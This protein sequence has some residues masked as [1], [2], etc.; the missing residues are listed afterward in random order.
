M[1]ISILSLALTVTVLPSRAA[2]PAPKAKLTL[3]KVA[4]KESDIPTRS[5]YIWTPAV[6]SITASTLPVLYILHGW[7]GSPSSMI[8]ATV[9]TFQKSFDGGAQPFIAVFPDGNAVTHPDSEWADSS[10]KKAMIETWLIKSVIP[11]VEGGN[12]RSRANRGI[13]G[14]SMGGYG[15]TII[16]LHHPDLFSKVIS[17]AGYYYVDDVTGAFTSAAKRDYQSPA[18][19][20]KIAPQLDWYLS[21]GSAEQTKTIRGQAASWVTKLKTVNASYKLTTPQA[22]HDLSFVRSQVMPITK[23]LKWNLNSDSSTNTQ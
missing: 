1:L 2:T 8:S 6:D 16:S 19:Y 20:L 5:V 18:N 9:A 14:Y 10:D 7:S 23:W 4:S 22:A 12:I 15:A 13:M 11:A 21:E 17:L 3:I